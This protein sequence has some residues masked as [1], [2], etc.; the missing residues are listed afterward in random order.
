MFRTNSRR[1][2]LIAALVGVGVVVLNVAL[3]LLYRESRRGVEA[4]L[5]RRLEDVVGVL[6]RFLDPDLVQRA[7]AEAFAPVDSAGGSGPDAPH[8]AADSLR[9]ILNEVAD[10]SDLA[11]VRVYDAVGVAFLDIAGLGHS[12]T[13]PEALDPAGVTAALTGSTVHSEPFESGDEFLMAGYA[14]VRDAAGVP[15]AAVAVEADARFFEAVH[16]L[17]FAMV[18]SA[19]LSALVLVG[20]GI[21]FARVQASLQ[22]AQAAMQQAESLAA[23]GRMAAGIAHEIRNPLGIIKATAARLKKR[24]DDTANPDE[25]FDY[26]SDEVERLN[27]ILTGYLSFARDEPSVRTPLD[28]T[29]LLQ[30]SLRLA[31]PELEGAGV[32]LEVSTPPECTV[33]GDAQ[34]LQQVVLNLVLNAAQAMQDGGTLLVQLEA[35]DGTAR[36]TFDDTGPGLPPGTRDRLFE[37]FVTT[38]EKGSGLG[39]AVAQRIVEEHRGRITLGDAPGGGA[40]VEVALPLAAV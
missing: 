23:M 11:N 32:R 18:G 14:P 26:I 7:A 10:A 6:G 22:H 1:T 37:P 27:T 5:G 39:L 20:L 12:A 17:R 35:A 31:A 30:R 15:I 9:S 40:R 3:G 2:L 8:A 38:K 13:A 16:R 25:R 33:L 4:E 29:L 24:Y 19:L 21:T 34:R 28:L 36:L